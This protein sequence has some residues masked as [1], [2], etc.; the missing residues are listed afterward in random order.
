MGLFDD[1]RAG[2]LDGAGTAPAKTDPGEAQ[3]TYEAAKANFEAARPDIEA[4]KLQA[5]PT[6]RDAEMELE[7]L[8]PFDP[9]GDG[10]DYATAE[11]S[12]LGPDETGHWPSRDPQSGKILKG[13]GHETFSLT[14]QGELEAGHEITK[15]EDGA[16]YSQ[17][18]PKLGL[19]DE[20]RAR[21]EQAATRAQAS[22][23]THTAP[24]AGMVPLPGTSPIQATMPNV[25]GMQ[26]AFQQ[27]QV[28]SAPPGAPVPPPRQ[29]VPAGGAAILQAPQPDPTMLAPAGARQEAARM[30]QT[31]GRVGL[32]AAGGGA[33]AVLSRGARPVVKA[34]AVAA[35]NAVGSLLAESIDPSV[36]PG[37][38]AA[39]SATFSG[40]GD[41]VAL[42][43]SAL[44]RA[45]ASRAAAAPDRAVPGAQEAVDALGPGNLPSPGRLTKTWWI[46]ALENV[47]E[48]SFFGAEKLAKRNERA[49]ARAA[50]LVQQEVEKYARTLTRTQ[51]DELILDVTKSGDKAYRAAGDA[52]FREVDG[53]A[54]EG[55]STKPLVDLRN[56]IVTE[57]RNRAEAPDLEELVRRI[58]RVLGVPESMWGIQR[59]VILDPY[60][61]TRRFDPNKPGALAGSAPMTG[62]GRIA[63]LAQ[64]NMEVVPS[65]GATQTGVANQFSP[66]EVP[67]SGFTRGEAGGWIEEPPNALA[68]LPF[69]E[70]NS[71]RSFMLGV[72]RDVE[73]LSPTVRQGQAKRI[74]GVAD[75]T[76]ATS[77]AAL[78][79]PEAF[80]AFRQANQFWKDLHDTFEDNVMVALVN[81]RPDDAFNMVVRDDSPK[82][83][84]RFRKMVLGGVGGDEANAPAIR[85]AARKVL[86]NPKASAADKALARTR[87]QLANKGMRAW[88]DFQGRYLVR[89]LDKANRRAGVAD[90]G[91]KGGEVT[92][93]QTALDAWNATGQDTLKQIFPSA[94]QRRNIERVLRTLEIT[95][96][97]T[98][99]QAM[100]LA[101]QFASTGALMGVTMSFSMRAM[102]SAAVMILT[103]LQI[104]KLLDNEEFITNVIRA[105]KLNPGSEEHARLVAQI[106]IAAA[107]AGARVVGPDGRAIQLETE[108][109]KA[110]D[111]QET[112]GIAN[113][114][115]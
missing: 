42:G 60:T 45:R 70:V 28:H 107:K 113:R 110:K 77:G 4:G 34:G 114:R 92:A 20:F 84:E 90:L 38:T 71:L 19:F 13:K 102:R 58:D 33:G 75:E 7:K 100:R 49:Q 101:G 67:G 27:S 105:Q 73:G 43:F 81:A 48:T 29:D 9:E 69:S 21:N 51:V 65:Q 61:P 76:L 111:A 53:L 91:A 72:G 24:G 89:L 10:Y 15:G 78:A 56:A 115:R 50:Q 40:V 87:L 12:G 83:I 32:E 95:Q 39:L 17:P 108:V 64:Q 31:A 85:E 74:A 57:Y 103:P 104:T 18:K 109:P 8:R 36:S 25:A 5:Y 79:D 23:Q 47:V 97:G 94:R 63:L 88:A 30:F 52:L 41:G 37:T 68:S 3:R 11:A 22:A 2:K 82:Q 55:V 62:P 112:L 93:G 98:G 86:L 106:G 26:E 35:G 96:G 16:Y 66:P 46:D 80:E 44:R 1:L 99:S 54:Q 6:W 14:E 59:G